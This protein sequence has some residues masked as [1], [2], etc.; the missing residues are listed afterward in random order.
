MKI[1]HQPLLVL[2]AKCTENRPRKQAGSWVTWWPPLGWLGVS[3]DDAL[4]GLA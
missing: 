2:L 1:K 4:G 3:L